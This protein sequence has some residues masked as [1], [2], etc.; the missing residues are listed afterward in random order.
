MR[1]IVEDTDPPTLLP[2]ARDFREDCTRGQFSTLWLLCLRLT[3]MRS[4][5]VHMHLGAL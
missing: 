4:R 2:E 3:L 5:L 1:T